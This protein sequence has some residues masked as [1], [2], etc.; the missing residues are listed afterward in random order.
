MGL[1]LEE[2][3]LTEISF[4]LSFLTLGQKLAVGGG[5]RVF[6]RSGSHRRST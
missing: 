5:K 2:L 1:S 4:G 3:D 6:I